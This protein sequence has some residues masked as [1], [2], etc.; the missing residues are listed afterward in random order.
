MRSSRQ[1]SSATTLAVRPVSGCTKHTSPNAPPSTTRK[2]ELEIQ[3]VR[4]DVILLHYF[5]KSM[6]YNFYEN[7][8][9]SYENDLIGN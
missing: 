1:C 8:F 3:Q 5:L 6:S 2:H 4:F 7:D 9:D